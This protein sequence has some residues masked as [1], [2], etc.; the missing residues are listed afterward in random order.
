M[1]K[2]SKS[3]KTSATR[4]TSRACYCENI[5]IYLFIFINFFAHWQCE[6]LNNETFCPMPPFMSWLPLKKSKQIRT[7]SFSQENVSLANLLWLRFTCSN[8]PFNWISQVEITSC[9]V[10]EWK[11]RSSF[12]LAAIVFILVFPFFSE[13]KTLALTLIP[14]VSVCGCQM[15]EYHPP[16]WLRVDVRVR[17]CSSFLIL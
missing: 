17:T 9:L 12:S 13:K 15:I 11:R 3:T 6:C 10:W 16:V 1:W 14:V 2:E 7:S 5:Y 8:R 4:S